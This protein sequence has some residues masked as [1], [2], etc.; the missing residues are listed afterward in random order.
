MKRRIHWKSWL[1]G[2]DTRGQDTQILMTQSYIFMNRLHHA[3]EVSHFKYGLMSWSNDNAAGNVVVVVLGTFSNL[4]NLINASQYFSLDSTIILGLLSL[5]HKVDDGGKCRSHCWQIVES[6]CIIGYCTSI[7]HLTMKS[8]CHPLTSTTLV[9]TH[10]IKTRGEKEK[11]L[12][13]LL[14]CTKLVGNEKV[15]P[16]L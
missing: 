2:C 4:P 6:C 15:P 3:H 9:C 13:I 11:L 1:R 5:P 12:S 10:S 8:I 14:Y 7:Q 16:S